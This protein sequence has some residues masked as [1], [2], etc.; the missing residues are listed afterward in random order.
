[1]EALTGAAANTGRRARTHTRGHA[2]LID[3]QPRRHR[4]S[5]DL[6]GSD[7]TAGGVVGLRRCCAGGMQVQVLPR[8]G[9]AGALLQ[10]P[11][12]ASQLIASPEASNGHPRGRHLQAYVPPIFRSHARPR[13]CT[14][15][16]RMHAE[17]APARSPA[18]T[19]AQSK[20][21]QDQDLDLLSCLLGCYCCA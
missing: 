1:M 18:R 8:P 3:A 19:H 4:S 13:T 5:W 11:S 20:Q 15:A 12:L 2:V 10:L 14:G 17:A 9:S 6:T 16:T 21:D 7:W